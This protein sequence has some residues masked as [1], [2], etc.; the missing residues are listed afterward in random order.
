MT[1]EM[2]TPTATV[3]PAANR[4][5][6]GCTRLHAASAGQRTTPWLRVF[7]AA[8]AQIAAAIHCQTAICEPVTQSNAS[9]VQN[10]KGV[11]LSSCELTPTG[12]GPRQNKARIDIAAA[13]P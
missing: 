12:I 10:A 9:T 7:S 5:A 11:S 13:V 1:N 6:F 8:N 4:F 2:T 3:A